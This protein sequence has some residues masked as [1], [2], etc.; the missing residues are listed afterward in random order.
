MTTPSV[1]ARW[2]SIVTLGLSLLIGSVTA[3][4]AG[5]ELPIV[6]SG[7]RKLEAPATPLARRTGNE[8]WLV[9]QQGFLVSTDGG[10]SWSK[11]HVEE[12]WRPQAFEWITPNYG[13]ALDS[14]GPV[15]SHDGGLSWRPIDDI[16][17]TSGLIEHAG[18][19]T[20]VQHH[21]QLWRSDDQGVSWEQLL[22]EGTALDCHELEFVDQR[23]GWCLEPSRLLA[24]E[25]GGR[26]W[27]ELDHPNNAS[28]MVRLDGRRAW[29]H[30]SVSRWAWQTLDAGESWTRHLVVIKPGSSIPRQVAFETD[31][32]TRFL[33]ASRS[34]PNEEGLTEWVPWPRVH[35][36]DAFVHRGGER[37]TFLSP[38]RVK[39]FED[40]QL[41]FN[42]TPVLL[43]E[44]PPRRLRHV[45]DDRFGRRWGLAGD[46][47]HRFDESLDDWLLVSRHGGEEA[48]EE[49]AWL[50]ERRALASGAD[51]GLFRINESGH[52]IH[53]S[54]GPSDEWELRRQQHLDDPERPLPP[55][56]LE[57]LAQS[58][59]GGLHLGGY[60]LCFAPR[61]HEYLTLFWS[62]EGGRLERTRHSGGETSLLASTD[63]DDSEVRDA[64]ERVAEI[65][66]REDSHAIGSTISLLWCQACSTRAELEDWV[67]YSRLEGGR[68]GPMTTLAC[69]LGKQHL[70]WS[71]SG[72]DAE[73][74]PDEPGGRGSEEP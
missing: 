41:V 20:W 6:D 21:D 19:H 71:P 58:P 36:W 12:T 32:G 22:T 11:R 61:E 18:P 73:Q 24:T 49:I 44:A 25:D 66:R 69:E 28:R 8:L 10:R 2:S 39:V 53:G 42:G 47:L 5:D 50:N 62:E 9:T 33:S 16:A 52:Q 67:W 48:L 37:Y 31:R 45:V 38:G 70:H 3:S 13:L 40:E 63:L 60:D 55:H 17:L 29:L 46:E 23:D 72:P 65:A 68:G 15:V 34:S 56:P 7:R 51:G 27:R 26:T 74:E 64:L 4:W 35:V 54:A 57:L 43:E 1:R 59:T 30:P 14:D